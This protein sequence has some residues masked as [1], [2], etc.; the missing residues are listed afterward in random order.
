MYMLAPNIFIQYSLWN[1]FF[2]GGGLNI[3]IVKWLIFI[4]PYAPLR[5]FVEKFLGTKMIKNRRGK[6]KGDSPP[7]NFLIKIHCLH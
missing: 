1:I 4:G 7:I 2:L 3:C 5:M 6:D